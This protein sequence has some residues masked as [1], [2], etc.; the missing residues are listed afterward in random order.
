MFK[1]NAQG[2]ERGAVELFADLQVRFEDRYGA[3]LGRPGCFGQVYRHHRNDNLVVKLARYTDA[4]W[5]FG[6]AADAMNQ[7]GYINYLKLMA[8]SA[9]SA[10][11]PRIASVN[12][13][14]ADDGIVYVVLMEKLRHA[15]GLEGNTL[16]KSIS[17]KLYNVGDLS[18]NLTRKAVIRDPNSTASA[19]SVARVLEDLDTM[20]HGLDLHGNNWMVRELPDGRLFPVITDPAA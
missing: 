10:F 9:P 7:D 5:R 15:K 20:H 16:A 3:P 2:T 6:C 19:V 4:N 8:S 17:S 13:W 12:I 18:H 11:F 14:Q 1:I